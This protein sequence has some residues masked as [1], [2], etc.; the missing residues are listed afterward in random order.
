MSTTWAMSP[1]SNTLAAIS[2][3]LVPIAPV[4][5]TPPPQAISAPVSLP[6][7]EPLI[8]HSGVPCLLCVGDGLAMASLLLP[9]A[10]PW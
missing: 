7:Y 10:V 5:L 2:A 3:V 6:K 4:V 9:F 1:T 8:G